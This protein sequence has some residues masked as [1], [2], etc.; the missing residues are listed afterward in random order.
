VGQDS[1]QVA[2]D[3]LS[4]GVPLG[5]SGLEV[6]SLDNGG[7]SDLHPLVRIGELGKGG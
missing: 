6:P 3:G 1:E 5:F 4:E 7:F 2:V